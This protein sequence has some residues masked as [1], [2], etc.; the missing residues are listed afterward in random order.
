MSLYPGKTLTKVEFPLYTVPAVD[1]EQYLT[2]YV[3]KGLTLNAVPTSMKEYRIKITTDQ[4]ANATLVTES[5]YSSLGYSNNGHVGKYLVREWITAT[6]FFDVSANEYVDEIAIASDENIAWQKWG[7]NSISVMFKKNSEKEN[8]YQLTDTKKIYSNS[9]STTVDLHVNWYLKED[10]DYSAY[11]EEVKANNEVAELKAVLSGKSVSI[12]GDSISTYS[13]VSECESPWY[14]TGGSN[15]TLLQSE[16]WW[17]QI[18][19]TYD[20]ELLVNDSI[21][22]A[23]VYTA[24]NQTS[25]TATSGFL[26]ADNLKTDTENPDYVFVF[27]GTNDKETLGSFAE[28]IADTTLITDNGD[29]SFAYGTPNSFS[30]ACYIMLN[31]I[32]NQN[33]D[34]KVYYMLSYSARAQSTYNA[35]IKEFCDYLGITTIDLGETALI[36]YSGNLELVDGASSVHPNAKGMDIIT[37]KV[38][39]DLKEDLLNN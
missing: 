4:L 16:T 13:G 22:G 25:P 18:I 32:V 29:G 11:I 14:G 10:F 19:D 6:E 21:G 23:G 9:V 20:M 8:L 30:D 24:Y 12:L 1:T 38:V 3:C 5:N 39:A 17:Q 7:D 27:M 33:P 34:A 37:D 31:K 28:T 15:T 26:R 36:N 2:F 35:V